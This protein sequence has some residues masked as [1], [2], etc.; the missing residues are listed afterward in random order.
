MLLLRIEYAFITTVQ[1]VISGYATSGPPHIRTFYLSEIRVQDNLPEG[2]QNG[3]FEAEIIFAPFVH[4]PDIRPVQE[5][6]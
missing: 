3:V 4:C 1:P 2:R 5:N 6:S